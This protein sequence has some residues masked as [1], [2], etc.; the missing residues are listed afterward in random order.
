MTWNCLDDSMEICAVNKFP[1]LPLKF[2]GKKYWLESIIVTYE[3][4][5]IERIDYH[6]D[7]VTTKDWK[8]IDISRLYKI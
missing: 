1:L 6:G 3:R 5:L 8:I 4:N 7:C 2:R